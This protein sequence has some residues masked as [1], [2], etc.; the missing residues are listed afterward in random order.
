MVDI[1]VCPV[2]LEV[3]ETEGAR[4]FVPHVV[5]WHPESSIGQRIMRELAQKPLEEIEAILR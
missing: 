4:G 5:E 2:C 3:I 1:A